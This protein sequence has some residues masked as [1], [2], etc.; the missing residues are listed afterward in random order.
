[1]RSMSTSIT[2]PGLRYTGGFRAKPTPAGVPVAMTSPGSSVMLLVMNSMSSGTRKIRWAVLESCITVPLSVSVMRSVC[3]SGIS[4]VVTMVWPIGAN[5]SHDLPRCHCTVAKLK[6]ARGDVVERGVAQHE[7]VRA[8]GA[9]VLRAASDDDGELSLVVDLLARR[10]NDD[11][12]AWR[13]DAAR[14]LREDHRRLRNDELALLGM[15][16]I[17]QPDAHDL[18]RTRDGREPVGILAR[19][20]P[21][22][23]ARRR[24]RSRIALESR[25]GLARF[26]EPPVVHVEPRQRIRW[27]ISGLEQLFAIETLAAIS[28]VDVED[29]SHPR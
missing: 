9:H 2:S 14:E 27:A 26:L 19:H 11:R 8:V 24:E 4:S 12:L 18:A 13:D 7:V 23:L 16:A 3:G 21:A 10:G 6:I 20:Q 25:R 29:D 5:V 28:A 17:V 1:M 15:I 22:V